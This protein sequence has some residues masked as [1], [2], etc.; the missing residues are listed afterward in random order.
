MKKFFTLL[1]IASTA[2]VLAACSNKSTSPTA[3]NNSSPRQSSVPAEVQQTL[4]HYA[5]PDDGSIPQGN[6][7]ST[8]T[9]PPLPSDTSYDIYA[10]TL[11][12]GE[13]PSPASQPP[14]PIDWS[15]KLT[16]NAVS[17]VNLL[18]TISFEHDQDSI[19]PSPS[20]SSLYWTSVTNHD[21]DGVTL[22]IYMKRGIYYFAAPTL[23]FTT[24]PKTLQWD[25]GQL[26]H[27]FA[28]YPLDSTNTSSGV[29][30]FSRKLH[31]R[32][33]DQGLLSGEW[34]RDD[35]G[36]SSGSLT[37]LWV[38]PDGTPLGYFS[39]TFTTD[40]TNQRTFQGYLSG[41]LTTQVIARFS[42][43]WYYDDPRMCPLCGSGHGKFVGRYQYLD[44]SA[45]GR[46]QGEFGYA[47]DPA[48]NHL[49]L[50]GTW[51]RFCPWVTSDVAAPA[52]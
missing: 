30:I 13:M 17:I 39:G 5:L 51:E 14:Q 29:A 45:S 2:L 18:S 3:D 44:G 35:I 24:A 16:V 21:F 23:T 49:P 32:V 43:T 9:T 25:F 40:S 36:G 7:Y 33:C 15:G 31:P 12:W 48:D 52:N 47:G 8:G 41:Y 38:G 19:L 28:Y 11:V 26:E 50:H 1:I 20:P 22:L 6:L 34:V 27:L 42:G 37:G 46:M 4:N 10:V